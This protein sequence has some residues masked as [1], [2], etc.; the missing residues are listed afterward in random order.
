ME[1]W[2]YWRTLYK[3]RPRGSLILG[4]WADFARI[5][6]SARFLAKFR[7]N[8]RTIFARSAK[9]FWVFDRPI[10]PNFGPNTRFVGGFCTQ[11]PIRPLLGQI[12]GRWADFAR[13]R[14]FGRLGSNFELVG[15]HSPPLVGGLS[16]EQ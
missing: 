11:P 7:L 13:I 15:G 2:L 8:R 6:P 5:R 16:S 12:Q 9:I 4:T 3:N 10:W 14:P 1:P